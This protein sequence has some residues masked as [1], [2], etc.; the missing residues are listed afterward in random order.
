MKINDLETHL[1]DL[2]AADLDAGGAFIAG[3]TIEA[4]ATAV[5]RLRK[6][7]KY[8]AVITFLRRFAGILYDLS[9]HLAQAEGI[10]PK[11]LDEQKWKDEAAKKKLVN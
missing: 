3:R 2:S 7:E 1:G 8:E 10:E 6:P 5:E 9:I 4:A 11:P